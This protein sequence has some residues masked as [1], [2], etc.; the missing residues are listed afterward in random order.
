MNRTQ[1]SIIWIFAIGVSAITIYGIVSIY[2]FFDAV[3][4]KC[5]S[6]ESI[7][8]Q[9]YKIE[10]LSCLGWAGPRYTIYSIFDNNRPIDG[11]KHEIDSCRFDYV[12]YNQTL[13]KIDICNKIVKKENH[14]KLLIDASSVDSIYFK[15][16]SL[17]DSIKLSVSLANNFIN[18]WNHAP[19]DIGDSYSVNEEILYNEH[20]FQ[21]QVY[22]KNKIRTFNTERFKIK[23]EKVNW[24]YIF[25]KDGEDRKTN[26]V[27]EDLW[28]QANNS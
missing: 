2:L 12:S 24:I 25:L 17:N 18:E 11:Y 21:F 22:S 10:K 26:K 8:I 3:K 15:N 14:K 28:H 23:E 4:I 9:D 20:D 16:L 6:I 13:Y 27:F 1:K 7:Q 19:L 5:E